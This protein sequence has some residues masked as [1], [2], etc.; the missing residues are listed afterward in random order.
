[1]S[2]NQKRANITEKY[3]TNARIPPLNVLSALGNLR[4]NSPEYSLK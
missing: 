2:L 3:V 4:L 1:M